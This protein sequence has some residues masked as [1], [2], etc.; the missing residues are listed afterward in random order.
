[1]AIVDSVAAY[2]AARDSH[3]MKLLLDASCRR[4]A[5]IDMRVEPYLDKRLLA[6]EA[7]SCVVYF[8]GSL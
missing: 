8:G 5:R 4:Y 3:I 1:M 2:K 7:Y 6:R